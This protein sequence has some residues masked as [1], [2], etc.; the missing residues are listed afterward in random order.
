MPQRCSNACTSLNSDGREPDQRQRQSG[1]CVGE[2]GAHVR[3]TRMREPEQRCRCNNGAATRA[4]HLTAMG[5]SP[6]RGRDRAAAVSERAEH[7]CASL[8]CVSLSRGADRAAAVDQGRAQ[9]TCTSL[10]GVCLSR[11]ADAITAQQRV[12]LTEQL[13]A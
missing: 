8:A 9:H 10:A 13:Q 5:V 4:P 1:S 3:F 7:T 12:R 6:I 11:G 2:G